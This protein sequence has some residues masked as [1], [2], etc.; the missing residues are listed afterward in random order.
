MFFLGLHTFSNVNVLRKCFLLQDWVIRLRGVSS[1]LNLGGQ[2][3]MQRAAAAQRH[4]HGTFKSAKI[5]MG[6]CPPCPPS[7]YAPVMHLL[8]KRSK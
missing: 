6:N 1:F 5:W 4:L 7:S 8:L 2:L 3:V